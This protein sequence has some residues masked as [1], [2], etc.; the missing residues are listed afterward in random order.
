SSQCVGAG[1]SLH[2]SVAVGVV[3]TLL[4]RRVLDAGCN[5]GQEIASP[6]A[7]PSGRHAHEGGT[8]PEVAPRLECPG[9]EPQK[10]CRLLFPQK[11]VGITANVGNVFRITW[12]AHRRMCYECRS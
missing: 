5:P 11:R 12:R 9:T 8:R 6:I 7:D 3:A 4:L 2:F 10:R 1:A